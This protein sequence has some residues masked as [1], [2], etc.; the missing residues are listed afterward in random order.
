MTDTQETQEKAETKNNDWT[1]TKR[2]EQRD[3]EATIHR[4]WQ[5]D[6]L[7]TGFPGRCSGM[8]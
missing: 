4:K 3:K 2:V 6:T 5:V 7:S 8:L 1:R